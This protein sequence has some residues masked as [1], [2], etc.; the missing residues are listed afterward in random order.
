MKITILC[1]NT[2]SDIGILAEWGFSAFIQT[3]GVSILFDTGYSDVYKHNAKQLGIDLNDT[4]F[5]NFD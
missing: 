3:K 5:T 2:S 1:E 4:N